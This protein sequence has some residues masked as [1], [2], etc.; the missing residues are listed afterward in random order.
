MSKNKTA[1]TNEEKK[2]VYT[3]VGTVKTIVL[4]KDAGAFTLEPISAYRFLTKDD[5]DSS[6]KIILKEDKKTS[7][8]NT[9]K[10]ETKDELPRLELAAQD[11]K[12][13]VK[14]KTVDALV[15]LKQNKAKI[16]VVVELASGMG[17]GEF[18]VS[19]ITI[20]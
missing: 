2:V 6:W 16:E 17:G 5:D 9:D 11:A 7:G 4:T 8:E 20:K 10:K 18:A 15:V 13:T 14:N 3:T 1:N 12:F 19:Q